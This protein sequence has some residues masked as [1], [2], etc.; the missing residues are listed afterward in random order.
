MDFLQLFKFSALELDWISHWA[1][2]LDLR[3]FANSAALKNIN[4]KQ[5]WNSIGAWHRKAVYHQWANN[6]AFL[7]F[8]IYWEIWIKP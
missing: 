6:R 5:Q 7:F 3:A 1:L 2:G 8:I 4:K